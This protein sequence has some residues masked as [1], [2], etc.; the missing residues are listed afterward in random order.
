MQ[1]ATNNGLVA[2][3]ANET[4]LIEHYAEKLVAIYQNTE[5]RESGLNWYEH[6][7]ELAASIAAET[8]VS[9]KAAAAVIAVCSPNMRWESQV[10]YTAPLVR[11]LR[12]GG[13][14]YGSQCPPAALYR[15]NIEKARRII[16]EGDLDAVRGEKVTAFYRNI[17]GDKSVVTLDVWAIRACIGRGADE[18]AIAPYTRGRKRLILEAAYHKA[19]ALVGETVAD[20]QAV[21]W[22][23]VR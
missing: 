17:I 1:Q 8:G 16:F 22:C 2:F 20:F 11:Y 14:P 5:S 21:I 18:K 23:A 15:T 13:D 12:A 7:R 19:A 3:K 9:M 4:E 10:A 6:A